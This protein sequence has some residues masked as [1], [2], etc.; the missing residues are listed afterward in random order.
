MTAGAPQT[1]GVSW[2]DAN[3]WALSSVAH[4]LVLTIFAIGFFSHPRRDSPSM[5]IDIVDK[6]KAAPQAV[7]LS[8]P[9]PAVIP[10]THQVF[11]ISRRAVT[12][13]T[14]GGEEVKTGNT[15][16]KPPDDERLRDG[17]A[18]TLP[19]PSEDY[20]VTQMPQLEKD[21]VI[22]YPPE[23]KKRGV[24][25]VVT[26]DLLIDATGIVRKVD[27]VNGPDPE[28]SSAAVQAALAFKFKPAQIQ[29]KPVAVRIRYAY[30]FVI[31]G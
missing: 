14:A 23:V 2:R 13:D 19:V 8:K 5:T 31:R 1:P 25:G 11:G 3:P 4:A 9:K 15:L 16:A 18:D 22:P 26:M 10:Q 20:L 17:D 30:R 12:V 27:L 29:D 24:Q 28:L 7:T 6:P 21:V